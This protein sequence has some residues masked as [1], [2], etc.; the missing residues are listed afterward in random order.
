MLVGFMA[1]EIDDLDLFG[2]LEWVRDHGFPAVGFHTGP[3]LAPRSGLDP[4]ALTPEQRLRLELLVAD[5]RMVEI[6][7]PFGGYDVSLVSPNP[8]VRLAAY[9]TLR[10]SF[11][12]GGALGARVITVHTGDTG[13][14]LSLAQQL[15][16]LRESLAELERLATEYD[17]AAAVETA[18]VFLTPEAFDVLAGAE[19]PHV[20][21]ALDIGH[22]ARVEHSDAIAVIERHADL[23]FSVHLHDYDDQRDHATLGTGQL[24]LAPVLSA[25]RRSGYEGP[26]MLELAPHCGVDGFL[27]S[28]DTVVNWLTRSRP[29]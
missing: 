12:L 28:R 2:Q 10:P 22:L 27:S 5:F 3:L 14:P 21:L 4:L 7:A 20:G 6:H 8:W 29:Q 18:D 15:D 25:L 13:A 17:I 23:I 11:A 24:N 1:W 26:L 9:E 19:L 16:H